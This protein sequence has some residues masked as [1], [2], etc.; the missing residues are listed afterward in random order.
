VSWRFNILKLR[1]LDDNVRIAEAVIV[2]GW[3]LTS[4]G[5]FTGGILKTAFCAGTTRGKATMTRSKA[6]ARGPRGLRLLGAGRDGEHGFM[7]A[8]RKQPMNLDVFWLLEVS[9]RI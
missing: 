2:M 5:I 8:G 7:N 6:N 9:L 1:S 4:S 3:S